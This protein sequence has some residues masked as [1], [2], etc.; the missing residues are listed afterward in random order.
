LTGKIDMAVEFNQCIFLFEFKVVADSPE[1]AA[2]QQLQQKNYAE[3]YRARSTP[4]P[5]I[6]LIGIEFSKTQ[7]QIVAFEAVQA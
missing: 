2:L 6:Y 1:G 5:S 3:K 7:K 4:A